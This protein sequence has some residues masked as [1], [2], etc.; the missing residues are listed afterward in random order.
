[1]IT[2]YFNVEIL[3]FLC[4]GLICSIDEK[5]LLE[6]YIAYQNSTYIFT[7]GKAEFSKHRHQVSKIQNKFTSITRE[8]NTE[9]DSYA[10]SD[11]S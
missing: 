2:S 9:K 11:A 5:S 6:V 4:L 7:I 1:M 8:I 3:V 10:A